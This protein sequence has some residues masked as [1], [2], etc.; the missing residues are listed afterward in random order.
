MDSF[1]VFHERKAINS[2]AGRLA[3]GDDLIVTNKTLLARGW[4]PTTS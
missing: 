4:G 1:C 3:P 2:T